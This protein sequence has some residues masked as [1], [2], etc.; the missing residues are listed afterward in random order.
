MDRLRPDTDDITLAALRTFLYV[1]TDGRG[2]RYADVDVKRAD[3]WL[4]R[5][6]T[7]PLVVARTITA[8]ATAMLAHRS[9]AEID[10]QSW[11]KDRRDA[12]NLDDMVLQAL[13][14]ARGRETAGGWISRI[15]I[16]A[17]GTEV[18]DPGQEGRGEL[19]RWQ[20]GYRLTIRHA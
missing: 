20:A 12:S 19:Y 17:L 18:P 15:D 3:G 13:H 4:G 6:D 14:A 10:V 11:A 1:P 8:D 7:R 5:L 2:D 9:Y 16:Q